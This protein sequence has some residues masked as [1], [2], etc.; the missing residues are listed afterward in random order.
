MRG[1]RKVKR[2][3]KVVVEPVTSTKRWQTYRSGP[4]PGTITF[5]SRAILRGLAY[6]HHEYAI[7]RVHNYANDN[8]ISRLDAAFDRQT[9]EYVR[10]GFERTMGRWGHELRNEQLA[11]RIIQLTRN[12]SIDLLGISID[13]YTFYP[14]VTRLPFSELA[15][16]V[17]RGNLCAD[18]RARRLV[19]SIN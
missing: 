3:K 6:G 18:K 12:C 10:S 9:V 13:G 17:D 15:F 4:V 2:K 1:D 11:C 14:L 5:A 7:A 8:G 16:R 19:R